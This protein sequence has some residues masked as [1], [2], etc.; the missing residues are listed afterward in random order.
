MKRGMHLNPSKC[1]YMLVLS[2]PSKKKVYLDTRHH[3]RR[4]FL[5]FGGGRILRRNKSWR[6]NE[7]KDQ[8]CILKMKQ[9]IATWR[10]SW[11][12]EIHE[13]RLKSAVDDMV[14]MYRNVNKEIQ[15]WTGISMTSIHTIL[16]KNLVLRKICS[17][18]ISHHLAIAQKKARVDWYKKIIKKYNHTHKKIKH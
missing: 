2:W 5:L 8:Y 10:Y 3:W 7:Y 13:G 1:R 12:S 18:W 14:M 11:M 15:Q 6:I 16:Y 4:V 17:R 9:N